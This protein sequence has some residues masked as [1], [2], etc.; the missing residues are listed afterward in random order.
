MA[1]VTDNVQGYCGDQVWLNQASALRS[2]DA[3]ASAYPHLHCQ[4]SIIPEQHSRQ[5]EKGAIP[6]SGSLC[7]EKNTLYQHLLENIPISESI[8]VVRGMPY[9][10]VGYTLGS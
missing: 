4:T 10:L 8:P 6:S 9:I 7:R 3:L 2:C 1:P 5:R